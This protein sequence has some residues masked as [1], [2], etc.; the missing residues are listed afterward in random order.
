MSFATEVKNELCF[1]DYSDKEILNIVSKQNWMNS[2]CWTW[3]DHD[4]FIIEMAQLYKNI[5]Q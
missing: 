3:K 1:L 4:N 2:I 5:Y